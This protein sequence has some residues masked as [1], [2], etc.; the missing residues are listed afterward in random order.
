MLRAMH[1]PSFSLTPSCPQRSSRRRVFALGALWLAI[2]S[3]V[4]LAPGCYGRNCDGNTETFGVE[5]GQGRMLDERSWES[6]GFDDI[7][8]WYPRQRL[9]SF[10]IT[11]LGGRTPMLIAPYLSVTSDPNLSDATPG[12]GD[13]VK[14]SNVRPNGFIL[15]ND[16]CSDFWLR[17]HVQVP[18]LPPEN[19]PAPSNAGDGG[20]AAAADD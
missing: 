5:A 18:S 15:K 6:S 19:R 14:I 11:A 16:T 12:S 2:S 4:L 13:A 8:L 1:V 3:V 9:Y 17:V 20:G 10:D 7:W